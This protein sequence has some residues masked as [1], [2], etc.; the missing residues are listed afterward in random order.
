[1]GLLGLHLFQVLRP[2][3]VGAVCNLKRASIVSRST[4]PTR[5][6]RTSK[7]EPGRE[8]EQTCAL[9]DVGVGARNPISFVARIARACEGASGVG[10]RRVGVAVIGPICRR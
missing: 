10:A 2:T 1:M 3:A 9:V 7:R 4:F 8:R 6:Q 5:V